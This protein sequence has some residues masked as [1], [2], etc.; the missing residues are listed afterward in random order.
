MTIIIWIVAIIAVIVLIVLGVVGYFNYQ[1][2]R[3]PEQAEFNKGATS[4]LPNGPYNGTAT[5]AMGS[6]L[7]KQ[8]DEAKKIGV[9]RFADGN[10]YEFA[11]S[12]AHS[13]TD[14]Q[15][16]IKIDYNQ[17]SNHW[18]LR[19][20]TDEIVQVAPNEYLGKIQVTLVP[21]LPFTYGYFR[22]KK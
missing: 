1:A 15:E 19:L 5:V 12:V 11:T 2:N 7:G 6:W 20:V 16:V 21:G 13:L 8:F 10:R 9:N 17:P 4:P 22:L 14:S 18:W 3:Q